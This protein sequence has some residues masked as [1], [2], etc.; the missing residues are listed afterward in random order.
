VSR[1][2]TD[3]CLSFCRA[4]LVCV[5]AN[6]DDDGEGDGQHSRQR[7]APELEDTGVV[8]ERAMG[9]GAWAC[10]PLSSLG[11]CMKCDRMRCDRMKCDTMRCDRMKCDSMRC[12]RIRHLCSCQASPDS[13]RRCW[14]YH[15]WQAQHI[16]SS[17]MG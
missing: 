1:R 2:V 12:D 13:A 6:G 11:D 3:T 8:G 15:L 5:Q 16:S 17:S 4:F 9:K 14:R 10:T 7:P